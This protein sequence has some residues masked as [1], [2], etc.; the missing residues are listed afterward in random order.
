MTEQHLTKS[1]TVEQTPEEVFRAI[2]N[3]RG[4]WSASLEGSSEKPG[5]EFTYRHGDIHVSRQRVTEAV[6]GNKVVW[7]VLDGTLNF[8]RDQHEWSGTE[9]RFEIARKGRKTEVRFTH[10]GLTPEKE[11]F[12]ACSKGWNF[13]IL[14]SLLPL[15]ATGR[16]Q[17]D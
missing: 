8:T 14:D 3:V 13:Y 7:Q 2:N 15:I 1:F 11:C 9:V 4:W 6:P 16:G 17:P 10:V 12:D 5:D